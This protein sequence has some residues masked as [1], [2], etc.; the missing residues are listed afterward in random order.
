MHDLLCV[1]TCMTLNIVTKI[2]H[3]FIGYRYSCVSSGCGSYSSTS[4]G[5][6]RSVLRITSCSALH[7]D[8]VDGVGYQIILF[9][10]SSKKVQNIP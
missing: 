5:G 4:V 6:N 2:S 10:H 7:G 8:V 9:S 3:F 1:I